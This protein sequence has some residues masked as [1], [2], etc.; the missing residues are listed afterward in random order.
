[1]PPPHQG[2]GVPPITTVPIAGEDIPLIS[3]DPYSYF[4]VQMNFSC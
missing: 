2:N 4:I 1:M 3:P